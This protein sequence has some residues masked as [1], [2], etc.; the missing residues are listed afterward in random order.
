MSE[1][2]AKDGQGKGL[3]ESSAEKAQGDAAAEK[4]KNDIVDFRGKVEIECRS[5]LPVYNSG[6]NKAYRAYSQDGDRTPLIAIVCER[7]LVPRRGVA[8]VYASMFDK[9]L[10]KLVLHGVVFWPPAKREV[11]VFVYHDNLGSPLLKPGAKPALGWRQEDVMSVIVKP[12]VTVLQDFRDRDFFHGAIRPGNMFDG[13]PLGKL[14]KI[15]LGDCLSPPPSS[16]QPVLY[17]TITRAMADPIAR[18]KATQAADLYALGVSIAV[19]MRHSDPLAGLSDD[20]IVKRKIMQGSYGAITGKDRFKGE[21]LELLRGLLHDDTAQR[22]TLEEVLEWLDGRRLS[23][24]Q[25]VV[26]KKAPRPFDLGGERYFTAQLLAMDIDVHVKDV[27]KAIEDNSFLNW[28]E[29]SLEDEEISEN[30]Q[31]ALVNARQQSSSKGYESCLVGNVSIA[32][33]PSAPL[34]FQNLRLIGDGI[35]SALVEAAVLKQPVGAFAEIFRNLLALN[36]LNVQNPSIIDVP[37]L[38]GKFEKCRRHIKTGK[39]GDGIERVIYILSPESPCL[40]DVVHDYYVTGPDDLLRAYEDLCKKG[41]AP[42]TFLD[43]HVTAFLSEKDHK[44]IEPYLYDL[45]MHEN[46]RVVAA[47]L[48]CLASIQ[49]RYNVENVP[50][51][52]KVMAPRLHAVI[53]RYHD[54]LVQDKMKESVAEFQSTGDLKKVSAIFDNAEVAKKDFASFRKAMQEFA[55]IESERQSLESCLQD[56]ETFGLDTGREMS[57]IVSSVLAFIVIIAT[58]FMYLSDKVS[59]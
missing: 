39:L 36:W 54:R 50:A 24:K 10:A 16:M 29:R 42:V 30:F 44:V 53:K 22:W 43:R 1:P 9:T 38:F 56:K 52:A 34:R 4:S 11:Y 27:K 7:H 31:K 28:I 3:S 45:N 37:G 5:P 48:K 18:G 33:D 8:D 58:A 40:S 23:P 17:E 12:M 19:F 15:I 2:A 49:R 47:T 21:I 35:G 32:L 51:L 13:N 25:S 41:K 46:H 6:A 20:E 57:A 14:P 55:N 26:A 59:F